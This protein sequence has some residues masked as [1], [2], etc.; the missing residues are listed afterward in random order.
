MSIPLKHNSIYMVFCYA[1]REKYIN[2][3]KLMVKTE[4]VTYEQI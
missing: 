4:A 2:L 1:L 3:Q